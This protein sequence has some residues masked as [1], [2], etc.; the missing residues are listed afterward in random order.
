MLDAIYQIVI[1]KIEKSWG[2]NMLLK[3]LLK[4]VILKFRWGGVCSFSHNATA[5]MKSTFEGRNYLSAG[6]EVVNAHFGYASGTSINCFLKDVEIG[7]Y[8]CI[9]G[10]VR[11]VIGIHPSS[12][13]MSIHPAFY[14]TTQQNG[15]TYVRNDK[16][17]VNKRLDKEK[18]ISIRIGND[19]WI[20]EGGRILEG[21]KIGDGAIIGTG[22]VVTKD[23][24]PYAIVGGVPAK[25]IK[26]RFSE[27]VIE[28]LIRLKW[29]DKGE[30]WIAENAELFDDAEQFFTDFK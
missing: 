11:T 21:I 13:F 1:W 12:N 29:W 14:S 7:R 2:V 22:A 18:Q 20:G 27:E 15:F 4:K 24:P 17:E 16:F 6:T 26:Y 9:A 28:K 23:I 8:V 5:D 30:E 19:V 25:T 3:K 10:Y